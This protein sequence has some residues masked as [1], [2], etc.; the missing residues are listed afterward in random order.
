MQFENKP[1]NPYEDEPTPEEEAEDA[2][3]PTVTL[4]WCT[5]CKSFVGRDHSC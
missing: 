5:K 2:E 4:I 3:E 1:K